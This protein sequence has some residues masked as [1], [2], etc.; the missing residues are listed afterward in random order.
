MNPILAIRKSLT[1]KV[2]LVLTSIIIGLTGVAGYVIVS[3]EVKAMEEITLDKARLAAVTGARAYGSILEDGVD[4]GYLRVNDL[5]DNDYQEIKGYEWGKN[6]RYHTKFDFFTDAKVPIIQETFM[7]SKDVLYAVGIDTHGYVPTHNVV[8][9]KRV[10]GNSTQDVENNRTK[11][12]FDAT[13]PMNAA[14]SEAPHLIQPYVRDTGQA[15]W[16]VS[17]PINV[18]GKHWG[19][20]R[21]GVSV[22]EISKLKNELTLTLLGVFLGFGIATIAIISMMV[23]RSMQPLVHLTEL[24]DEISTGEKLDQPVK[25]ATI[26]EI[27]Q[28][29]KSVE[30]LRASLKAA[31]SRLGE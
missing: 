6:P 30:R 18:K 11:R 28:M 17:A 19:A 21:I 15:A 20:F 5:F 12:I 8:Y 16:D 10:I 29:A 9:Q 25:P 1:L 14:K 2:S 31:M 24:A 7:Q 4:S 23:R 3:R 27:G 26:D 13:V 22:D